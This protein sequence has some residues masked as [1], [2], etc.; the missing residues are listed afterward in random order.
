MIE[1]NV[2]IKNPEKI[3]KML[4]VDANKAVTQGMMFAMR[5]SVIRLADYI[6]EHKLSGQKLNA[7]TG[8]LK[9]SIQRSG[10]KKVTV[11][12]DNIVGTVG[13]N[14]EYACVYNGNT[15]I[16]MQKGYKSIASIQ[17]GDK[18]LTQ[19]GSFREVIKKHKF[20][21]EEK[22]YLV[23]ITV[24]W[25]AGI[26]KHKITVTEDHK[27]LCCKD[28]VNKW[29]KAG[30]LKEGDFLF[31]PKKIPH[32]KGKRSFTELICEYCGNE[33]YKTGNNYKLSRF[34]SN[35]CK[36]TYYKE[37]KHKHTGMKRSIL[38]K[39]N[40][41]KAIQKRLREHPELHI[42]RILAQKGYET[43]TEK[44]TRK[45]L[46][47]LGVE[48][49]KQFSIGKYFVDFYIP[50]LKMIIEADGDYWHS[51]Q[52]E[53]I[54]RDIEIKKKLPEDWIILHFHFGSEYI[55]KIE[56]NPVER[57]H[58][59][60]CNNSINS[61]C[62]PNDFNAKKILKIKH[63]KYTRPKHSHSFLYDL[64]IEGMHSFIAN[65]IVI[66]NSI[67]ETGGTIRPKH[68]KYLAIPLDAALTAKGVA[69]GRPRDFKDTFFAVSK[70]GN[71]IMFG[72]S[73]GKVVPLFAMKKEVKIPKRPYMKPSLQEK[74]GDIIKFFSEDIQKYVEKIWRTA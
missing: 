54:K 59:M 5:R 42:N 15:Q 2:F 50:E 69:R 3:T 12:G 32:N 35:K 45:W 7:R 29:I 74:A 53:D 19:D 72:K 44:Q 34:C 24:D 22:P 8:M 41:S 30:E 71:L 66:S 27:I 4:G 13:T 49:K 1:I 63:W 58:Y 52:S 36:F 18:V 9:K 21:T 62:S 57:V 14:M 26:K 38:A 6:A 20:N 67:H 60:M 40:M 25:R 37:I 65:G 39:E 61:Y 48:F 33:Y 47:G 46:E 10:A 68:S 23:E 70:K 17:V 56:S 43:S 16:R 64:T 11:M 31:S 55:G 28:G 73:M 51:N